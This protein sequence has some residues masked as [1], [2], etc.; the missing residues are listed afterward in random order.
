MVDALSLTNAVG[1]AAGTIICASSLP[2]IVANLRDPEAS[3]HQNL[4][5]NILMTV[6]NCLW[7]WFGTSMGAYPVVIFCSIGAILNASLSVQC[8]RSQK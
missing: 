3:R 8:L 1:L 4:T 5:R 7:V 2:Q 6:G